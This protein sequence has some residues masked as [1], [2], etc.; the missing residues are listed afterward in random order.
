MRE[1]FVLICAKKKLRRHRRSHG[2]SKH[3][4]D[5]PPQGIRWKQSLK[6]NSV[7]F[8]MVLNSPRFVV[9]VGRKETVFPLHVPFPQRNEIEW[10]PEREWEGYLRALSA[11]SGGPARWEGRTCRP[12]ACTPH[13][14]HK[15]ALDICVLAVGPPL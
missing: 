14:R 2:W 7:L 9:S 5:G 6:M 1:I 15:S 11:L 4:R 13:H 3:Q 12:G 10:K 8:L